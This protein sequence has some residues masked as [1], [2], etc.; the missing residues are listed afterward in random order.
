MSAP[1]FLALILV[2]AMPAALRRAYRRDDRFVERWMRERAL[3][4]AGEARAVVA[5]YLRSARIARTWGG[6]GGAMLP[7]VV[8]LVLHGRVT[9]LGFGTDGESAP[10]AFGAIF[11]GYLAGVL[12]AE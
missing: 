2:V 6:V 10:L 8:E 11:A 1:A 3:E 12:A 7:T 9:V 5:R 4:P